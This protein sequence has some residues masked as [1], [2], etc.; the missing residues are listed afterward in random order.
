MS[1]PLR[2]YAGA[3]SGL[4]MLRGV[5]DIWTAQNQPRGNQPHFAGKV[6]DSV[7]GCR[8]LPEVVFVGVTF[9]GLYRTRDAGKHWQRVLEGD[10]RW[11]TVDP[12]DEHVVYAGTEPVRLYRSEDSGD[13]WEE[14]QSLQGLPEEVRE[15]WWFPLSPHHGHVRHIYIDPDNDRCLYLCLEHGGIL[16]SSDRGSTWKTLARVLNI[17]IYTCLSGLRPVRAS[18]LLRRREDFFRRTLRRRAGDTRIE[19]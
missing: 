7:W 14:L 18:I 1:G 13:S 10:I 9:D 17:P 12:T 19:A 8:N 16:R 6:V 11:V 5:N 3:Q 2:L 4:I 15:K